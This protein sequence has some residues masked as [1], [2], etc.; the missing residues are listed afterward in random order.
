MPYSFRVSP[1]TSL[2]YL[3]PGV[4][5]IRWDYRSSRRVRE[6]ERGGPRLG[7]RGPEGLDDPLKDV[8]N[9]AVSS[10]GRQALDV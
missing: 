3:R 4:V 7:W 9:V 6:G 5:P 10:Q 8:A 2:P 1:L